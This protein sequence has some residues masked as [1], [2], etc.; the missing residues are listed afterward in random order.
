MER[1]VD[2]VR[3]PEYT[4]DRRCWACTLVNGAVLAAAVAAVALGGWPLGAAALAVV[5][6]AVIALRGYLVPYTPRFAPRIVDPLPVSIG[7]DHDRGP[8]SGDSLGATVETGEEVLETLV[9]AGVVGVEGEQVVLDGG[10]EE[11]WHAEMA[12][13][14]ERD[15]DAL[16]DAVLSVADAADART[17][18]DGGEWIVLSDGSGTFEGESWLSRPLAIAET[19]AVR[20]L[21]GWLDDPAAR[22]AAAG[23]LRAFLET[24]PACER[25]LE[26]STTASC[27]G[28][29]TDPTDTPD[30]VLVCTACDARLVRF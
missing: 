14:R 22:L 30:D 13:L 19:A 7:P 18:R 2:A 9:A 5:G 17:V 11:E 6:A 12:T 21:E 27:C 4:G 25:P 28:G 24:C 1:V 15:A 26:E 20:S 3:R 29:Y 8:G 16:A 23:S 10:F